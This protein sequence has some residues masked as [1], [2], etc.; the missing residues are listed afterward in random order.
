MV[1]LR[2]D[3]KQVHPTYPRYWLDRSRIQSHIQ[4]Q[5][6]GSVAE[7]LNLPTIRRLPVCTPPFGDQRAIANIL[8]TLDGKIELNRRMN[9]TLEAMARALFKSWFVDF[10]PVRAK[11]EGRDS[12]LPKALADLLPDSFEDSELGEIPTGVGAH[13]APAGYR[14]QPATAAAQRRPRPIL[15]HGEHADSGSVAW[16]GDRPSLRLR[17]AVREWRHL[18]GTDYTLP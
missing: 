6:D 17:N 12:E 4:G 18:G 7:R 14:R 16:S 13:T 10:D 9:E 3:S 15:G 11:A 1:L 8:G 5:R 2:P